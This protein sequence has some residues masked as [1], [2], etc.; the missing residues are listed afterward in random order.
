LCVFFVRVLNVG[1]DEPLDNM[2]DWKGI[3][4]K[5]VGRGY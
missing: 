5:A 2:W 4:D 1:F 3:G